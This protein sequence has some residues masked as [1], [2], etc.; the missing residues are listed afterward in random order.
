MKITFQ[1]HPIHP[2]PMGQITA[3]KQ[4]VSQ[5][6]KLH[7][8]HKNYH[9]SITITTPE[10]IQTLNNSHRNKNTPTDVLSFPVPAIKSKMPLY[11]NRPNYPSSKKTSHQ[12]ISLGDIIIALEVADGQAKDLGHTLGRELAFLTAHGFLHLIGF[13]HQAPQEEAQM[14]QHQDQILNTLGITR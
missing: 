11:K 9:I 5:G 4:V 3:L 7:K 12:P 1:N 10:A 6:L 14:I 13:D 2:I 8:A